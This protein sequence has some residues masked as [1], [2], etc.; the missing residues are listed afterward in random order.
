MYRASTARF[1][2]LRTCPTSEALALYGEAGRERGEAIERHLS[3]CEFCGAE[4]QLLSKHYARGRAAFNA[5]REMPRHLRRLA[6]ELLA[7]P[8]LDRARFVET[9]CELDRMTLTDA[10]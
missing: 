7:Q 8:S 3:A 4:L 10:A 1:R 9:I 6:E 2:K 5:A